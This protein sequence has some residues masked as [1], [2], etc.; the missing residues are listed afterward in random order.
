MASPAIKHKDD[1]DYTQ[2]N[3]FLRRDLNK[4][5]IENHLTNNHAFLLKRCGSDEIAYGVRKNEEQYTPNEKLIEA[6][7]ELG[8]KYKFDVLEA[9]P[10]VSDDCGQILFVRKLPGVVCDK[11]IHDISGE[12]EPTAGVSDEEHDESEHDTEDDELHNIKAGTSEVQGIMDR[13]IVL[14]SKL[15]ADE[16]GNE[17]AWDEY[18][19]LKALM[20]P[21]LVSK[22]R[23]LIAAGIIDRVS[24]DVKSDFCSDDHQPIENMEWLLLH[25]TKLDWD[26]EDCVLYAELD[27]GRPRAEFRAWATGPEGKKLEARFGKMT[28][29]DH[30]SMKGRL[31]DLAKTGANKPSGNTIEGYALGKYTAKGSNPELTFQKD[32]NGRELRENG[33]N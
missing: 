12:I 25:L 5:W 22:V 1:H 6:F 29:A 30:A 24:V 31:I 26:G 18:Y 7:N 23:E 15:N 4:L 16:Q 32:F 14:K 13:M 33:A 10:C 9:W 2:E 8:A 11:L 20:T 28:E 27:G 17:D 3:T 21:T 19:H